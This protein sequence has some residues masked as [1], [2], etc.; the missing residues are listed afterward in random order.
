[1]SQDNECE[2]SGTRVNLGASA[3]LSQMYLLPPLSVEKGKKLAQGS[4]PEVEILPL[5]SPWG[6]CLSMYLSI[7]QK[8]PRFQLTTVSHL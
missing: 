8:S 2:D 5:P 1:M 4:K 6:V 3:S 7:P